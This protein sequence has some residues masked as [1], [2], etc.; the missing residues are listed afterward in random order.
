MR[1]PEHSVG[2]GTIGAP[3]L[4][5]GDEVFCRRDRLRE[6]EE[7]IL[8]SRRARRKAGLFCRLAGSITQGG[9]V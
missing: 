3:T 9:A 2:R 4:F 6:I 5:V 8:S 1:D 7:A